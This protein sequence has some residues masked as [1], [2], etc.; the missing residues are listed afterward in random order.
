[1]HGNSEE[2]I[3]EIK[4]CFFLTFLI[5]IKSIFNLEYFKIITFIESRK[6]KIQGRN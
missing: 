1:M 5:K 2:I 3:I 6:R 4:N